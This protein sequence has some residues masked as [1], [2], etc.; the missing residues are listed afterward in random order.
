MTAGNGQREISSDDSSI[1]NPEIWTPETVRQRLREAVDTLRRLPMPRHGKPAEPRGCWPDLPA[2]LDRWPADEA[3]ARVRPIPPRP[4]AIK[5]MEECLPAWLLMVVD[6]RQRQAV[7]LRATPTADRMATLS[8][9]KVGRILGVS[10]QTVKN[11][12]EAALDQIARELNRG[13]DRLRRSA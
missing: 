3:D 6:K 13:K 2:D 7:Y 4:L 12:E 10:H 1:G 8:T 5:Q 9:R 11:W